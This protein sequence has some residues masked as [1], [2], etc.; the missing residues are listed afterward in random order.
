MLG[1]PTYMLGTPVWVQAREL[2][3][4]G[5]YHD[6]M[7][8]RHH[9]EAAEEMFV[10]RNKSGMPENVVDLHGLHVQEALSCKD[11]RDI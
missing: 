4:K 7:M 10:Q 11:R 8:Q 9:E 1:T 6:Q 3:R 5:R 2:S